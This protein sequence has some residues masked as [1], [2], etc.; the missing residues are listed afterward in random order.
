MQPM[1]SLRRTGGLVLCAAVLVTAL[2]SLPARSSSDTS[3]RWDSF[4]EAASCGEPFTRTP[5]ASKAGGLAPSEPVL[6]PFG[7]YFGRTIAQVRANLVPWVVPGSGGQM[8][9]VHFR[10]LPAFQRVAA[11][12]AAE[13]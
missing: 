9:W 3:T 5:Y 6:G 12:L 13:A 11:G 7:T 2:P 10:A 8:V 1:P 4:S